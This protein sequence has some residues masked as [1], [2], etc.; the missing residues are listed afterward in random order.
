MRSERTSAALAAVLLAVLALLGVRPATATALVTGPAPSASLPAPAAGAP[1]SRHTDRLS[2]TD[3]VQT[4]P[5]GPRRTTVGHVHAGSQFSPLPGSGALPPHRPRPP[6]ALRGADRAVPTSDF[7]R[8]TA[9]AE[10][11][12]VRGPPGTAG[13]RSR[14]TSPPVRPR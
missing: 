1:S 2:R 4:R 7:V 10:L 8:P 5:D 6:V 3:G 14:P 13:H 9:R 12:G 11:L